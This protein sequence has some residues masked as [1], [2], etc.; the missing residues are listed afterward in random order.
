M[1]EV[2]L[3]WR[4]SFLGAIIL[5]FPLLVALQLVRIQTNPEWV[6][7]LLEL[8]VY[9]ENEQKTIAPPR[10]QIYDR[11]GN[12][13]AGNRMVYEVGV[14]LEL[15]EDPQ[16]IAQTVSAVLG[17]NYNAVYE[18]IL[19]QASLEPS[20]ESVHAVLVDNVL[21]ED[22]E[23]LDSRIAAIG[24]ANE[25]SKSKNKPVSSFTGLVYTP[26]LGRIYPEKTLASNIIGFVSREG[27][28]GKGYFGIEERFNDILAA[29]SKTVQVPL[30]PNRVKDLPEVPNGENLILTIDREIQ[31]SMEEI[32]DAA[33][34]ESGSASGTL[35]VID[36]KTGEILALAMTPRMD[37]NEFW[38]YSEIFP[39]DTPFNRSV[40][41][42]YEPGSVFKVL[43]MAAALD[44]GAV[45][46][47]TV[48]VD[49]GAIEVGGALIYNWNM[50]AWGPQDMQGCLQ[51][52]LNV[53]LAWVATQLGPETLYSYLQAFGIGH[54][55][56]I[57]LAGE[58]S[59]RLKI[60]GDNDWYAADLGTNAFGQGVS[61]TP[62]QMAVAVSAVANRGVKMSPK[63]VRSVV[64]GDYQHDTEQRISGM[65][66]KESTALILSD[67]LARSLEKESSDALVTG[68]RVAGKTGTAE[69][70][71]P[72]GYTTNATNAS[73]VGW[74]PVD[75]P[76]FLVYIW[77]EKPSTAPWGSVV[78]APVFRQAAEK[79]VILLDIPPD[80]VRR[81]LSGN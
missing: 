36:P 27:Q 30:D 75:D 74:G 22:I 25:K 81:Q 49:T 77:L 35:V 19:A 60:P 79:L 15:V 46:P 53:C 58:V 41:Q 28:E 65:P 32:I 10:G 66:I 26:H 38:S 2:E 62:V 55:T 4:Y 50:G 9:W 34:D 5:I 31:R 78:A 42:A 54:M 40:S 43:T 47:D 14:E 23:E 33:V 16:M 52:S 51:H 64:N 61:V 48:F 73:F 18:D 17:E 76:G 20:R 71:T 29:K 11:W 69:I 8:S 57:D 6:E 63:I 12:L 72:L 67:L 39:K 45:T 80:D 56:G 70:P 7:K 59:G 37:L 13:L 21:L 1:K 44:S 3:G 24:Q 68:Y